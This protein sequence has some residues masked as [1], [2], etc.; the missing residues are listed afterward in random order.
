VDR[1]D[2]EIACDHLHQG[3]LIA[4]P[5]EAVWGIGCDPAKQSAV[6]RILKLKQR[7][8]DKGLILVASNM[9]QLGGLLDD[10]NQSQIAQLE[11]SWPGPTTWLIP[12]LANQYPPWIKG[13]HTSVAVRVSAHPVIQELCRIFASPIVST[14]A[15]SSGQAE[16]RSRLVLEEQFADS[17]D[18]IV[19]GELG[20][21]TKPT[22]IRDLNSGRIIR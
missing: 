12:D 15:N 19:Q 11:N 4:Y 8:L 3:K 22:Q 20:A 21:E 16:I 1:L 18:Y 9:D 2:L 6:L 14:S 10:L 5:T 13:K 17:I 7:P